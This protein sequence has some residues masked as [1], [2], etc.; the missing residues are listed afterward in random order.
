MSEHHRVAI[1]TGGRKRLGSH[2]SKVLLNRGYRVFIT[3]RR[4]SGPELERAIS[5]G[6]GVLHGDPGSE[7]DARSMVEQVENE[8]G[9]LD[10]LVNNASSYFEGSLLDMSEC[11]FRAAIEGS[12]YPVF[13]MS[14]AA[15]EAMYRRCVGRIVN[16]GFAG[17][18]MNMGYRMVAAH[19]AAKTAVAVL[20]R[21]LALELKGS[22]IKMALLSPERIDLGEEGAS[23][24][25][26]IASLERFIA[27][28]EEVLNDE[29]VDGEAKEF[30]I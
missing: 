14:R 19:G 18:G 22:G 9:R 30:I 27:S 7:T 28:F 3:T 17:T 16:I 29:L 8:A 13:F 4:E 15:I 6:F 24:D 23:R 2:M 25:P 11:E 10:L 26:S 12:I 5:E 1:V 21:S 20:T